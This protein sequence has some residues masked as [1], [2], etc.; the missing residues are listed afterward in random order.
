MSL[1][2]I[3]RVGTKTTASSSSIVSNR[4]IWTIFSRQ[5]VGYWSLGR[6]GHRLPGA[7]ED[8]R[9]S[10]LNGG[11]LYGLRGEGHE[12]TNT[13]MSEE[14]RLKL[15]MMNNRVR[16]INRKYGAHFKNKPLHSKHHSLPANATLNRVNTRYWSFGPLT[17]IENKIKPLQI[18]ERGSIYKIAS[19]INAGAD[20]SNE[21][22][23]KAN[24]QLNEVSHNINNQL[25]DKSKVYQRSI[26]DTT[27]IIIEPI[28]NENKQLKYVLKSPTNNSLNM[29]NKIV[30]K[31]T[32]S[33]D[34]NILSESSYKTHTND[35]FQIYTNKIRKPEEI[36][37]KIIIPSRIIIGEPN[38]IIKDN[39]NLNT[40]KSTKLIHNA[41]SLGNIIIKSNPNIN[42]LEPAKESIRSN[43]IF[44]INQKEILKNFIE[45][46]KKNVKQITI[47]IP[48]HS[49]E[50]ND[51]VS[52]QKITTTATLINEGKTLNK[53]LPQKK[54][55]NDSDNLSSRP[56]QI[57]KISY[58]NDKKNNKCK[59]E[60]TTN[61]ISDPIQI[62]SNAY[63]SKTSQNSYLSRLIITRKDDGKITNS[64]R[65]NKITKSNV[66]QNTTSNTKEKL[67][68]P[69]AYELT[70]PI[71]TSIHNFS[72]IR[73]LS[74]LAD[75]GIMSVHSDTNTIGKEI[76][77]NELLN[78]YE[79][80]DKKNIF[81]I[82][83]NYD[84]NKNYLE[85]LPL[86]GN[87]ITLMEDLANNIKIHQWNLESYDYVGIMNT[88]LEDIKDESLS[89]ALSG[90]ILKHGNQWQRGLQIRDIENY[91]STPY[92][93]T[94]D[95]KKMELSGKHT[96]LAGVPSNIRK[97][98]KRSSFPENYVMVCP[99]EARHF[100]K[101]CMQVIGESDRSSTIIAEN[102]IL[103]DEKNL[104]QY[105]LKTL[106]MF[107]Y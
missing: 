22:D 41:K 71:D 76:F 81:D 90:E 100:I 29:E 23:I 28:I 62:K 49:S 66:I 101:K 59:D 45:S 21:R 7:S 33:T 27:N 84:E 40:D 88:I 13:T 103:A 60:S 30:E 72:N 8:A 20:T 85:M 93:Y 91:V 105:G 1:F 86:F 77:I 11:T 69:S 17:K 92:P 25:N 47:K 12:R 34:M 39:V 106:G 26:I 74:V 48:T 61:V 80:G 56:L 18:T 104:K 3:L 64:D 89:A 54:E 24:I 75:S 37:N 51:K 87:D 43:D 31:N 107:I 99:Y 16:I 57:K 52:K 2:K 15:H 32:N 68:I 53:K 5:D 36:A 65:N 63:L 38:I 95:N 4:S 6:Q 14:R 98:I 42:I 96:P 35:T 58:F 55:T 78:S 73:S 50:V 46:E 9:V 19:P 70:K 83:S 82:L 44:L 10:A 79:F 67:V 97:Y 102:L 94:T